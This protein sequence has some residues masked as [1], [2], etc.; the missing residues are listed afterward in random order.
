M[1]PLPVLCALTAALSASAAGG[2]V[3]V[4]ARSGEPL[5]AVRDR[6]RALPEEARRRGVEVVLAPGDYVLA[7]AL[8]LGERDGG[9]SAEYPV[10]WRGEKGAR[11]V[12]G[13]RVAASR[14]RP[15]EDAEVLRRLPE[16]ARGKAL[17]ADVS[18]EIPGPLPDFAE[19]F[20][21][22]YPTPLV[23]V[24]H[25]FATPARWPNEG[26]ARFLARVDG[27]RR[28][29]SRRGLFFGGAF[30]FGDPRPSRWNFESGVW[31]NGYWTHD[32]DNASVRAE[33]WGAEGGTNGVMRL[34][35][36]VP[37]G[38]KSG[39]WG[40]KER[41]FYA[42]NM[43][44]ELDAPGEWWLDRARKLLYLIPPDGGLRDDDEIFVATARRPL[45]SCDGALAHFAFEGVAFE[46]S[47]GD[48]LRLSG[49]DVHLRGC[50]V[51]C[52]GGTGVVMKGDANSVSGCE[53][54]QTGQC[55]VRA[56]GGDR[57]RLVRAGTSVD[58][59][60]IHDFGVVRRTYAPGI[61]VDGCGIDVRCNRIHDAPHSAVIY[62]GNEHLFES[63]DV[64]GVLRETGDAGAFY[65]GRDWTTQGNVLRFNCVHDLG[66]G[67]SDGSGPG[68][69]AVS[70][71]N[72]MGFYFD[73]C[74]CGDEVFGNT[75]RDV[76][77]GIMIGGGRD[78]PV[79]SNT[80]VRCNIGLSIDCR[81]MTWRQWNT[82]G[83]GW[84]LE[85]K[86]SRLGYT[87]GVWA[88]RYP[89]LARIMDDHPREPLYNPVAG[90]VFVDCREALRLGKEAPME[91]MAP[92]AGNT[93]VRTA[94]PGAPAAKIDPRVAA[95]FT[96]VDEQKGR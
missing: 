94:A 81:G 7:E 62:G 40:L 51:S 83:D 39:T 43:I 95:G 27:G 67:T 47:A 13:V 53:I 64:Y 80:F 17:V 1:R 36:G 90:N 60:D 82:P 24:N 59:N 57:R 26:F 5:A 22:E 45:V 93:V 92:I 29:D 71:E 18:A 54:L 63:N 50:R 85:E 21:G 25:A 34:A 8:R 56:E 69:D 6:V 10:K 33:R 77:R 38:V 14:F 49:N 74:D 61:S 15:V 84:N 96:V 3:V 30:V 75:F 31:L 88:A 89:R 52:C 86:A 19:S 58:G 42:F 91:R 55:G 46:Y 41:R 72:T 20:S 79:V 12:G 2:P 28:D 44:E 70:G 11:I 48:G 73:D 66:P 32:W 4:E 16:S 76:A 9:A 78:H 35:G 37:Y 87:N 23:F 68:D 65:T